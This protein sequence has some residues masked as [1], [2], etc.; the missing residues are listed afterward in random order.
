ML[1]IIQKEVCEN[2]KWIKEIE[3]LEILA[4]SES[5]PGPLSVNASTFVGYK[6]AGFLGALFSTLG[7][8]FPSFVILLVIS[9]FYKQFLAFELI[10]KAFM[11][12]KI[13]VI[14]LLFNAFFKLKKLININLV[15]Y[16]MF[17]ATLAIMLIDTIFN[18]NIP[19]LS[20]IIIALGLLVGVIYEAITKTIKKEG[21][22]WSSLNFFTPSF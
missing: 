7:L 22:K 14:V 12:L 18:L 1:P 13:A 6:V 20:L 21:E 8:I 10:H 11:G 4:I 5:T 2:K 15:G 3:L 16:I 17:F 19:S 9:F